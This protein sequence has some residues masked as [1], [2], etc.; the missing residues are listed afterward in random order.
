MLI[1][2]SENILKDTK[3]RRTITSKKEWSR[4][5][6]KEQKKEHVENKIEFL[7]KR[8]CIVKEGW[9]G[10]RKGVRREREE[11]RSNTNIEKAKEW[12]H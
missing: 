2:N 6:E 10:R 11:S 5:D 12:I 8:A 7:Y 9:I 4:E 1:R 3:R